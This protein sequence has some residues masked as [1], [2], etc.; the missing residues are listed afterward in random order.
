MAW[1][2]VRPVAF[3]IVLVIIAWSAFQAWM[4]FRTTIGMKRRVPKDV[5]N[6]NIPLPERASSRAERIAQLGFTRL[7]EV[8]IYPKYGP[9]PNTTHLFVSQDN[10]TVCVVTST[11][12]GFETYFGESRLVVTMY[13][14]GERIRTGPLIADFTE[15]DL[16]S[17]YQLHKKHIEGEGLRQGSPAIVA[18]IEDILRLDVIWRPKIGVLFRNFQAIDLLSIL[19]AAYSFSL[20]TCY[21]LLGL[22]PA[23]SRLVGLLLAPAVSIVLIREISVLRILTRLR[24]AA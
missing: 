22:N 19:M 6:L 16:D 3:L 11:I 17:A 14:T 4:R 10:V 15:S 1:Y 23:N 9:S 18:S 20:V 5:S 2:V 24:K 12:I 21:S 7:G 8:Q 13:P